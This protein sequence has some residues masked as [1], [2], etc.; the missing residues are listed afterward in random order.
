MDQESTGCLTVSYLAPKNQRIL[1]QSKLRGKNCSYG[2][3]YCLMCLLQTNSSSKSKSSHLGGL[4]ENIMWNT[5]RHLP[6]IQVIVAHIHL[7]HA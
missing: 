7:K 2:L 1:N 5:V 3:M 4:P 6:F